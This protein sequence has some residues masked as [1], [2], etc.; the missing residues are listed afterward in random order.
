MLNAQSAKGLCTISVMV[1][2]NK[3]LGEDLSPVESAKI[4]ERLHTKTPIT[5]SISTLVIYLFILFIFVMQ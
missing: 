5:D 4:E 1:H 2:N 3:I